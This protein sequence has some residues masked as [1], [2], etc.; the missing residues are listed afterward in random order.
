MRHEQ[1]GV[2]RKLSTI[3]ARSY[4]TLKSCMLV[5]GIASAIGLAG[6]SPGFTQTINLGQGQYGVFENGGALSLSLTSINGRVELGPN[7]S[8]TNFLSSVGSLSKNGAS[9]VTLPARLPPRLIPLAPSKSQRRPSR[10]LLRRL[11]LRDQQESMFTTSP[12]ASTLAVPHLSSTGGE[13]DFHLQ[14]LRRNDAECGR[15]SQPR[16]VKHHP[17]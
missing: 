8:Y 6:S 10:L 1:T 17:E 16:A 9:S 11:R 14:R 5:V 4:R 12:E 15:T 13:R 2:T 7:T 3:I